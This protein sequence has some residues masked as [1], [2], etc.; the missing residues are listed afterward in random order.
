M[1]EASDDPIIKIEP[2][3]YPIEDI[4][5]EIEEDPE[6]SSEDDE[7][8]LKGSAHNLKQHMVVHEHECTFCSKTFPEAST[9]ERHLL[10]HM[11]ERHFVCTKC[12]EAFN[13]FDLDQHICARAREQNLHLNESGNRKQNIHADTAKRP[14]KC[15]LCDKAFIRSSHLDQHVLI[16]TGERPNKCEIC[17][18]TFKQS[19]DLKRHMFIHSEERPYKCTICDKAFARSSVLKRHM[20]IHTGE[21]SHI[22]KN[23]SDGN[24][25]SSSTGLDA[26]GGAVPSQG[27]TGEEVR[28]DDEMDKVFASMTSPGGVTTSGDK[29]KEKF[30]VASLSAPP[31]VVE[32][33]HDD[34]EYSL[35]RK[36][37]YPHMHA[38]LKA[39]HGRG[40]R[41]RAVS[42]GTGPNVSTTV[43]PRHSESEASESVEPQS[44]KSQQDRA[45]S[46]DQDDTSL[47]YESVLLSSESEPQISERAATHTAP[48]GSPILGPSRVQF[49]PRRGDGSSDYHRDGDTEDD[50]DGPDKSKRKS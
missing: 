29:D 10:I 37:S 48:D 32:H 6:S 25:G 45:T 22:C 7:T 5:Q 31:P 23:V 14:Y 19:K 38:P 15:Q 26:S 13:K 2:Q 8:C 46:L 44:T 27:G 40:K 39:T 18:K 33:F 41:E 49:S 3:E 12:D 1:S 11:D 4:K 24:Y 34:M 43:S 28:L 21:F 17:G 35:H 50:R 16:H 36:K 30:D 42:V 47:A 9:L 20:L